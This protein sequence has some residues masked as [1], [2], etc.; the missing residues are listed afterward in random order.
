VPWTAVVETPSGGWHVYMQHPGEHVAPSAGKLGPGLDIRGDGGIAL[1][2][3]SRRGDGAY[4]WA[5]GG[6]S[7]VPAMPVW[8]D[9]CLA[10]QQKTSPRHENS[11][12]ADF[13]GV[14]SGRD[15]A[16]LAGLLRT[17]AAAQEGQRN[18][19]LFW[20]GCR[21]KEL[22]DQGAPETW[23]QVLERAGVAAGLGKH[24]AEATVASALDR[25]DA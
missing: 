1:L 5:I 10:P 11:P 8:F 6:P 3:P 24:E 7:T 2:P 23:V 19:V 12:R 14:S 15:A 17:L 25:A 13:R 22:L 4:W 16:R 20:C 21:L 9:E 18:S